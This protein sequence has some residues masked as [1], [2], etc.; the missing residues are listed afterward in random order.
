M[1]TWFFGE[2]TI[3]CHTYCNAIMDAIFRINNLGPVVVQ[4]ID[5]WHRLAMTSEE[6]REYLWKDTRLTSLMVECILGSLSEEEIHR[7]IGEKVWWEAA[8]LRK[9]I[10]RRMDL[11]YEGKEAKVPRWNDRKTY[12]QRYPTPHIASGRNNADLGWSQWRG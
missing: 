12:Y 11:V 7:K 1:T 3:D 2:S 4:C 8:F 6:M 10:L 9:L 5:E